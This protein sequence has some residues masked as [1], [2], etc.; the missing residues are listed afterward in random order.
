MPAVSCVQ[1]GVCCSAANLGTL[2]DA[3]PS[4]CLRCGSS[5]RLLCPVCNRRN[6]AAFTHICQGHAN[7]VEAAAGPQSYSQRPQAAATVECATPSEP[8]KPQRSPQHLAQL[9]PG[10]HAGDDCQALVHTLRWA[11]TVSACPR[12]AVSGGL[13]LLR[14]SSQVSGATSSGLHARRLLEHGRPAEVRWA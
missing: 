5:R 7:A 9:Q 14:A 11:H 4:S 1:S 6:R 2:G 10:V 3:T 12:H 8:S 13:R